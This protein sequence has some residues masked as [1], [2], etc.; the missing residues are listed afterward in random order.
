MLTRNPKEDDESDRIREVFMTTEHEQE[1]I[2]V[3]QRPG[4]HFHNSAWSEN[5]YH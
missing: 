2:E 4:F 5:E 1:T 3:N